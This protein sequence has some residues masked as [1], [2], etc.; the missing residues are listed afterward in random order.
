MSRSTQNDIE[1][2]LS[3]I[4][5]REKDFQEACQNAARAKHNFK[6]QYAAAYLKAEGT[7]PV[8]DAIALL[9]CKDAHLEHVNTDAVYEF[10]KEKLRDAQ[11]ALSAR[12]S[13][14]KFEMATSSGFAAHTP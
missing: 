2:S 7:L 6:M 8:K 5:Q 4:W 13:L 3:E 10:T 14:L 12:Q 1:T 11:S 9:K